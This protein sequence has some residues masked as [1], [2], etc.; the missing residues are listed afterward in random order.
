[1]SIDRQRVAAVDELRRL[2]YEWIEGKWCRMTEPTGII[3]SAKLVA[4]SP[5]VQ[6]DYLSDL[7]AACDHLSALIRQVDTGGSGAFTPTVMLP[8]LPH[9][10][11][12]RAVMKSPS[13]AR[14]SG[15]LTNTT[16]PIKFSLAGISFQAT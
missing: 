1:M 15:T 7:S 6:Y 12:L 3:P 10:D 14:T 8:L 11:V 4:Q 13:F 16:N 9:Q 2:G 5:L